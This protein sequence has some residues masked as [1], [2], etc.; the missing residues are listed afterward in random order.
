MGYFFRSAPT[1]CSTNIDF[2][3]VCACLWTASRKVTWAVFYLQKMSKNVI[4]HVPLA[5]KLA[6]VSCSKNRREPLRRFHGQV[7]TG[8]STHA[9]IP[10]IIRALKGRMLRSTGAVIPKC[11]ISMGQSGKIWENPK[12]TLFLDEDYRGT[13]MDR[14]W[15]RP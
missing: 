10:W 11:W 15:D 13:P 12:R 6:F 5:F 1:C 14:K 9:P 4:C 7:R 8:W 2:G 3:H